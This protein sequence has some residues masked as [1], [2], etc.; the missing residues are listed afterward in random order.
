[1]K[2]LHYLLF[3]LASASFCATAQKKLL[4]VSVIDATAQ[5]WISGANGRQGTNYAV[6]VFVRTYKKVEFRNL[7][8]GKSNLPFN[9]EFFNTDIPQRIKQGDTLL[10]TAIIVNNET[11]SDFATKR[12]PVNYKGEA[13][14]EVIVDGKARYII[15]KSIRKLENLKTR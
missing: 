8:L 5:H 13:L 1:M 14:F 4:P 12:L 11:Q 6:K 2:I 3:L 10:L 7:W 9:V 15:V